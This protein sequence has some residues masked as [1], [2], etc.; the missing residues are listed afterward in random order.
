M[1]S[2]FRE[3]FAQGYRAAKQNLAPMLALEAAMAVLVAIYYMWPAAAAV[4]SRFA[5]WQHAGGVLAASCAT[6]LAG[7]LLSEA[8]VVYLHN[9]GRWTPAN[10]ENAAFKLAM[11]F[12][13]GAIVYEFYLQQ[14]VW[15]GSGATWSVLVPKILVDQFGF[16]IIWSTPYMALLTRWQTLRYS[17]RSLWGELDRSF[18]TQRMLP[19]LVTNWMLWI[20]AVT[21]IYAMPTNLQTPL[22][23]FATAIWGILLSAVARETSNRCTATV[24]DLVV[25]APK[26]LPQAAAD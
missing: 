24:Q 17:F 14:A 1:P 23:I 26:L 10:L 8:S 9:G 25:P 15:F 16:T 11:F 20:P 22:F 3:A 2:A 19:V 18:I 4:L 6:A 13:S 7:G 12:V 5:A 21:L